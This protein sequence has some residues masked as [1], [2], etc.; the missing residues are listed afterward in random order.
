MTA[1]ACLRRCRW[2]LV[3]AAALL[4][5]GCALFSAKDNNDLSMLDVIDHLRKSD[6]QIDEIQ[7][8]IYTVIGA[9]D[10]CALFIAGAK[11]E[12]YRYDIRRPKIKEKLERIAQTGQITILGIDFPAEVNGSFVM[13]TYTQHPKRDEIVRVFRKF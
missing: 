10:G 6:L 4:L 7:P 2:L 5:G 13:L 9:E 12:I 11:V 1:P 8:T 3:L